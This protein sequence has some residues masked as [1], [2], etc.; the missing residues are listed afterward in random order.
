MSTYKI[1]F[2]LGLTTDEIDLSVNQASQPG[3]IMETQS[4]PYH[5]HNPGPVQHI[6]THLT[7]QLHTHL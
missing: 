5:V 6:G 1:I 7:L 3:E 4:H 2:I